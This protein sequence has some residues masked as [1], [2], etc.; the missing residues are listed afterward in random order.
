MLLVINA[1]FFCVFS[2]Y[3]YIMATF[4]NFRRRCRCFLLRHLQFNIFT[5]KTQGRRKESL[6][7]SRRFV[8]CWSR[9]NMIL[10][11]IF[12]KGLPV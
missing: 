4:R 7:R 12:P 5:A 11:D 6:L 2:P 9:G 10:Q 8:I 1:K 3:T